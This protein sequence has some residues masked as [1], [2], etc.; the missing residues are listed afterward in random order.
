MPTVLDHRRRDLLLALGAGA[1]ALAPRAAGAVERIRT[2]SMFA[3][4]FYPDEIPLDHDADLTRVDGAPAPA[5]GAPADLGGRVLD[6]NGRAIGGAGVEIWQCDANGRYHHVGDGDGLDPGF[7]GYGRVVTD[8]QGRYRFRTIRPV[9]YGG[10]CPHIHVK[11]RGA[12]IEDL[13]TQMFVAGDPANA[14]D[15][16]YTSL[17]EEQRAS[18]TVPF[19]AAKNGTLHA[20]FELVLGV[21]PNV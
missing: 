17:S 15:F 1:L 3:G 14:D 2:V 5:R 19:V 6:L 21:A 13:T 16:I 18:V 12:G 20:N 10:R 4:P 7:Q 9:R 8:A 11:V